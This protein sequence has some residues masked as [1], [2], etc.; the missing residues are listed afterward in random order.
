VEQPKLAIIIPAYNE[1]KTIASVIESV[2]DLAPVIVVNDN[3]SDN[4]ASIAEESGAQVLTLLQNRGYEGAIDAGFRKANED[5]YEF[6][7]TMD[8]DGQHT[9]QAVKS[10]M[11]KANSNLLGITSGFRQEYARFSELIFCRYFKLRFGVQDA[12]CGLKLYPLSVYRSYGCFDSQKLVGSELL[13]YGMK[14]EVPFEQVPIYVEDREE[15]DIPR[16]GSLF[17]ANLKIFKA[18]FRVIKTD[19]MVKKI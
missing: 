18:L 17:K 4:T 3:S 16:Y 9:K 5:G 6:V 15:D 7:L 14:R 12:L 11:S 10:L 2:K 1:E 8:A 19:F 13:L